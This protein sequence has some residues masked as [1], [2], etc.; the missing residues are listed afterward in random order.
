MQTVIACR[1]RRCEMKT[2]NADAAIAAIK[3]TALIIICVLAIAAI[4]AKRALAVVGWR[5]A[6]GLRPRV[7]SRKTQPSP[8][9]L[10]EV[11]QDMNVALRPKTARKSSG[12]GPPSGGDLDA[13]AVAM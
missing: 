1:N 9:P 7:K 3:G 5:I 12:P 8:L 11:P 13:A 2:M 6:L 10:S 4:V